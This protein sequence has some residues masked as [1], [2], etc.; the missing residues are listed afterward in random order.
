MKRNTAELEHLKRRHFKVH[1]FHA[2]DSGRQFLNE[3][4]PQTLE[5]TVGTRVVLVQNLHVE[6]GLVNGLQGI[7]IGFELAEEHEISFPRIKFSLSN[8]KS[9]IHTIK[10]A[11]FTRTEEVV[12]RISKA[13]AAYYFE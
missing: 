3:Q 4:V 11:A 12:S 5:L 8:G 1:T 2:E 13:L 9:L 10:W 7:V 6:L